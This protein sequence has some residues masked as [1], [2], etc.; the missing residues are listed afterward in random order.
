MKVQASFTYIPSRTAT[1]ILVVVLVPGSSNEANKLD[2]HSELT[3][4][5]IVCEPVC[6]SH[7]FMRANE[8]RTFRLIEPF[9][10]HKFWLR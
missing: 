10:G 7:T 1:S 5:V 2:V 8:V 4:R 9:S 6:G 3:P